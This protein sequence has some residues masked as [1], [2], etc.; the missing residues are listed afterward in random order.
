MNDMKV[1]MT[2]VGK[3]TK[4]TH[5]VKHDK[6]N[7]RV[8]PKRPEL[9]MLCNIKIIIPIVQSEISSAHWWSVQDLSLQGKRVYERS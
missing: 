9:N 5:N 3:R 8:W 7:M 1:A 2:S 4:I 6:K